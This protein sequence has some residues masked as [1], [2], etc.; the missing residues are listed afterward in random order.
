MYVWVGEYEFFAE[1]RVSGYFVTTLFFQFND[2]SASDPEEVYNLTLSNDYSVHLFSFDSNGRVGQLLIDVE[3]QNEYMELFELSFHKRWS[4][5]PFTAVPLEEKFLY[6][7]TALL[8]SYGN[9]DVRL[10]YTV[11]GESENTQEV[12]LI[13]TSKRSKKNMKNVSFVLVILKKHFRHHG[14]LSM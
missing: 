1:T 5:M 4:P 7:S 12:S 11:E 8:S 2:R 6:R 14:S 13:L 10:N 9:Y 3:L